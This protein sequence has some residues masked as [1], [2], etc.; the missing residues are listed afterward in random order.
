MNQGQ[1]AKAEK[2][3][4][5]ATQIDPQ[6]ESAWKYLTEY[7][8]LSKRSDEAMVCLRQL[9]AI[10]ERSAENLYALADKWSFLKDYAEARKLLDEALRLG[11]PQ[12]FWIQA[13]LLLAKIDFA[14][15]HWVAADRDRRDHAP[16]RKAKV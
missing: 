6:C 10:S 12:Q 14:E 2:S 11:P 15:N 5:Q 16:W 3:W 1:H 4:R 8:A 9:T 7:L 13:T